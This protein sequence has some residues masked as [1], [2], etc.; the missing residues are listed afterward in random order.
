MKKHILRVLSVMIALCLL[1]ICPLSIFASEMPSGTA[2][3]S[4]DISAADLSGGTKSVTCTTYSP[5]QGFIDVSPSV[6]WLL[7][8]NMTGFQA[9]SVMYQ[10]TGDLYRRKNITNIYNIQPILNRRIDNQS[11]YDWFFTTTVHLYIDYDYAVTGLFPYCTAVPIYSNTT[12]TYADLEHGF[13]ITYKSGYTDKPGSA[14]RMYN[15]QFTTNCIGVSPLWIPDG[16]Y[17]TGFAFHFQIRDNQDYTIP[18]D[19]WFL[20]EP[21]QAYGFIRSTATTEAIHQQTIDLTQTINSVG[22]SI[23]SAV[24]SSADQ[25]T[26]AIQ[27]STD[28]IINSDFG[29]TSPTNGNMDDGLAMGNALID[30]MNQKMANFSDDLGNAQTEI[31]NDMSAV[32]GAVNVIWGTVPAAIVAL[33]VA[34]IAFLVIRKLTGR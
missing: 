2:N 23:S 27:N 16:Y 31:V 4:F 26:A 5:T 6:Y 13:Q 1:V 32:S 21:I 29:Y 25:I 19:N 7:S 22:T 11:A 34:Y 3:I 24:Q 10:L 15:F 20:F 14:Y 33:V 28:Q 18:A 17:L 9:D 8:N 30:D 12:Q